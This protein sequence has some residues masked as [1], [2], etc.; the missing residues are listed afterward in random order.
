MWTL[1]ADIR[2]RYVQGMVR[3]GVWYVRLLL[4][5]GEIREDAVATA[6]CKRVD[7]YRFTDLWNGVDDVAEGL[8]DPAWMAKATEIAG[9]VCA[10][11][12]SET[13]SL[14]RRVLAFLEP[15]LEA[16][17][18]K[19]VGPPPV[20]PFECWTYEL[21]WA[22]M[23]SGPGLLGKLRNPTHRTA[24][25]RKAVGLRPLPSPDG[26]LHIMNV[27]VPRSPLE[28][29]PR[30]ARTLGALIA[31]V[32]KKHPQVR[33]L[34][35]NTWLNE[36]PRFHEIFPETWFRNATVAAPGN[37][38]NWWGQFARRDGDFHEAAAAQFRASGGLFPFRALRCHAG[39]AEIDA[40]LH[41]RF[42]RS[43]Q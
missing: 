2:R 14:E 20:R 3:L 19:D 28:D 24:M 40:H 15:T 41:S 43:E 21:G 1:D 11:A 32:R 7:L 9:W 29:L 22:G 30:L 27:L 38:R 10:S 36:H 42:P 33:E 17:L 6:L 13:E 8:T 26:V 31:E 37:Y 5:R 35:C 4:A 12:A 16:R 23:A 25:L 18:P 39:L 34:W